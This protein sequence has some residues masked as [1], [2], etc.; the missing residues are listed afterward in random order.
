MAKSISDFKDLGALKKALEEKAQREA[1]QRQEQR[2][3]E[4]QQRQEANLF[5]DAVA[6]TKPIKAAPRANLGIPKPEPRAIQFERD[7]QAALW[8]SLSDEVDIERLLDT[9]ASL[10]YRRQGVDESVTRKL[11]KGYWTVQDQID[12]HGL[13]VDQA[14]EALAQFMTQAIKREQRCL[15]IIHGKGLGSVDRV[16]VLKQKVMRWL[17][18]RDEVLAFCQ[19]RP[20]DGGAGALIVLLNAF[21][22]H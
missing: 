2:R 12:L 13:R 14:R 19:A 1:S 4:A 16:P 15:R 22:E 6:G 18:Q 20:N 5:R 7:E 3:L 8:Q 9:D 10:S 17:V 21:N 11:R